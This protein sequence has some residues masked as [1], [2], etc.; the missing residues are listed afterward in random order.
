MK[1]IIVLNIEEAFL[2]SV[3]VGDGLEDALGASE[4]PPVSSETTMTAASVSWDRP[5]AARWRVRVWAPRRAWDAGS[6]SRHPRPR[7]SP[8]RMIDRAVVERRVGE[9]TG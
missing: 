3:G 7:S 2:R 9:R 4:M 8:P 5:R 1:R 6:G